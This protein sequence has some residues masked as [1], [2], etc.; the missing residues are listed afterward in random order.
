M[1]GHK[2]GIID[3]FNEKKD[4]SEYKKEEYNCI[5][6]DDELVVHITKYLKN[7]KTYHNNFNEEANG[8]AY[9]GV[10]IIPPKSLA[11]FYDIVA[12]VNQFKKSTELSNLSTLILE[13]KKN[14][15]YLIHYGI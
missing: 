11:Y 3:D 1:V 2:F 4:Y 6:I 13:A 9:T 8:L 12:T 10:T 7:L 14:E 5:S 15:K